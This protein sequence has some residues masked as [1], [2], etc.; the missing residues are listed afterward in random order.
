MFKDYTKYE[1]YPNGKIWSYSHKKWLKPQTRPNGYQQVCLAD[2]EGK[3]KWYYLHRVV[4]ES[5]TGEPIP[6]GMQINHRNEIKTSNFFEN[7]QLVTPKENVN[8]GSRNSRASK[9]MTNNQKL[10]KSLTNNKKLSKQVGAYKNGELVFTFPSTKEAGRNGFKQSA[11][12]MC[13]RNCYSREGNNVYRGFEWRY[14]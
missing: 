13:C 5:V 10:L 7:L 1:V 14:I 9:S 12:S 11:V 3:R 2:N 8:F 4:W 6:E